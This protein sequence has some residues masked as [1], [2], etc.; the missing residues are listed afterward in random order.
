MGDH[1]PAP[2][3]RRAV[4]RALHRLA[5]HPG[6]DAARVLRRPGRS[7]RLRRGQS[8]PR[9]RSTDGEDGLRSGQHRCARRAGAGRVAA[10]ERQSRSRRSPG[11]RS[12][13]SGR[14]ARRRTSS[15]RSTATA[16]LWIVQA[17][18]ITTSPRI[19]GP[20]GAEAAGRQVSWSNANVNENFPEPISPL[21]YSIARAG[22]YHYF[23]NLGRAFGIS[24]AA[25]R[26]DGAGAAADHRRARRADVL[27]PHEHPRRAA[28]G[29]VRRP[30]RRV[31]QPVRRRRATPTT[32]AATA[33]HADG[34]HVAQ[35]ARRARRHRARRRP[36]STC[37]SRAACEQFERDGRR[38]RRRH[39]SRPAARAN[40]CRAARAT[41]AASS[42]SAA[43]AGRTRRSPTPA[44]WSATALL[45]RLLARAFPARRPAG[46]AQ[47][48]A[49][50][51][52]RTSSA[53]CRR[54][55]LWELSRLVRADA[56]PARA[57]RDGRRRRTCSPRSA[58]TRASP[59][60]AQRSTTSS[61]TGASAA[62]RS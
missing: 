60:S 49:Q 32:P 36:G 50:G 28:L 62:R 4:R 29:A 42:R 34:A 38:L 12:T 44:R 21:L 9:D 33:A 1:R 22:Y 13:S 31:V 27:Q 35:Q 58:P 10:A 46:A 59:R 55:K 6:R 17:R 47:H 8:R 15:G 5:D 7:A 40:R 57:V 26:G 56:E 39:A 25:A 54:S 23:R 11:W 52:A 19:H 2:G 30:A 48:A 3:G 45:Q 20:H 41:S 24:R 61:R 18:P 37:S 14:S 53:A 43:T 51:A 16:Q